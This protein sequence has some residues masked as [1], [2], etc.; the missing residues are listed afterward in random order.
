MQNP[1]TCFCENGRCAGTIVNNSVIAQD[2]IIEFTKGIQTK[3]L[4]TKSTPVNSKI[5]KKNSY[6]N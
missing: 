1:A 4:P 5:F 3:T 2:E 6:Q